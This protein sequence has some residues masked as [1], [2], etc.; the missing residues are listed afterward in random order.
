MGLR[1]IL[2]LGGEEPETY[3]GN[4]LLNR[5]M[6]AEMKFFPDESYI[7]LNTRMDEIM[8]TLVEFGLTPYAIPAGAAMPVGVIPY[9]KAMEELKVQFEQ[10]KTFPEKMFVAVGTGGT[11][12][13]M[14]IGAHMLD[15]D[16]DIIG[17]TVSQSADEMETK[18]KNLISRTVETYPE[19][20]S[21]TPKIHVDDSFLGKG[22]GVLE[23]GVVTS[24]EMF[25]KMEGI[26]LDPVYTGKAGLA[27]I[28]MALAGDIKADTPTLFYHTGGQPAL[29]TYSELG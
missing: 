2:L 12:A 27:L 3:T 15:L 7:T 19:I 17:V 14:I 24:I 21:F 22:Y 16:V 23:D 5:F 10:H 8:N 18:I 9:A 20:D 28:R 11:Q 4:V 13:G 25:A 6:G 26:I 1:C 29:F